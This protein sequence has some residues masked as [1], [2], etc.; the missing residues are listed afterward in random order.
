MYDIKIY[1]GNIMTDCI[2]CF[3]GGG[4]GGGDTQQHH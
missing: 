3:R 4:G 2:L 1:L